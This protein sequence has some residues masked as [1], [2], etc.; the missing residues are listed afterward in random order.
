VT[1]VFGKCC[2]LGCGGQTRG[3]GTQVGRTGLIGKDNIKIG[4]QETIWVNETEVAV[5]VNTV[6]DPRFA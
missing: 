6:F 5:S 3:L 2:L 1:H 4:L